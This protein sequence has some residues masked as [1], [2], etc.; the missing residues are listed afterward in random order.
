MNQLFCKLIHFWPQNHKTDEHKPS[1]EN[2]HHVILIHSSQ[3]FIISTLSSTHIFLKENIWTL[4][5]FILN[6]IPMGTI[7]DKSALV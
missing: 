3:H 7:D 1:D 5:E 2:I 4:T 6:I